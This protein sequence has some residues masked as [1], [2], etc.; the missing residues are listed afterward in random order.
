M[1][2]VPAQTI[3]RVM[4][5]IDGSNFLA[6]LDDF[7]KE[8]KEIFQFD[9]SG[10]IHLLLRKTRAGRRFIS[11]ELIKTNYYGSQSLPDTMKAKRKEERTVTPDYVKS[12]LE[13]L[14]ANH[15]KLILK[16]RLRGKEKGVDIA[17]AVDMLSMA[18][19]NAYDYAIV[20]SGDAD[21][22]N[23]IEELKRYGKIVYV[24][25][26]KS[27]F[28]EELMTYIDGVIYLD[29]EAFDFLKKQ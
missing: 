21:F 29:D 16:Q 1:S 24:A 2:S 23:A 26:F 22:I 5:F 11:F 3:R 14:K 8:K 17:L 9:C 15:V 12:I 19:S 27:R 6:G 18:Y 7:Q 10:L 4:I 20:V 28:N 25:S 13:N